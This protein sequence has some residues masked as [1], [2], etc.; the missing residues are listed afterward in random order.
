MRILLL[1]L[2]VCTTATVVMAQDTLFVKDGK[3]LY[4]KVYKVHKTYVEYKLIRNL[5]G[6][7]ISTPRKRIIR[8]GFEKDIDEK[9]DQE[10]FVLNQPLEKRTRLGLDFMVLGTPYPYYPS[11]IY[12]E[13]LSKYGDYGISYHVSIYFNN[14]GFFGYAFGV[15]LKK[16]KDRGNGFFYGASFE[17]GGIGYS[18]SDLIGT[19]SPSFMICGTGKL[20]WQTALTERLG[21]NIGADMGVMTDFSNSTF[22]GTIFIGFNYVL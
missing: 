21:I 17:M 12:I 5:D 19:S 11:R 14:Y 16:Y 15:S 6:P 2:F 20:G 22:I 4:V 1:I 8:I 9:T 10:I 18:K 7:M 13:K 3:V